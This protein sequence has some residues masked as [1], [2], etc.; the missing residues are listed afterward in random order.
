MALV[1][2]FLAGWNAQDGSAVAALFSPDGAY[3]D[4][5]LNETLS[6]REG[7]EGF[8]KLAYEEFSSDMTFDKGYAVERPDGY[9]VEWVMRGTHDR[10]GPKLP[11]TGKTFTVPGVSIG[12]V[13]DGLIVRNTDYWSLATFL[14][15]AGLMPAP[16]GTTA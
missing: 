15:Q 12:E 14:V 10:S 4:A 6:G 2:D 5:A 1:D 8:V 9:A 3:H 16:A 11:A 7:I 13:R